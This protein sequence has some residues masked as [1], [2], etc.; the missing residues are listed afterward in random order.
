[1]LKIGLT[2]GF[3]SGKSAVGE[4]FVSLGAKLIKAD[5]I[6][7]QLMLPG[8]PVYEKVVRQFGTEILNAD[9]SIQRAKLAEIA[10]GG[11][12][13]RPS[14][15]HELNEI[16]HPA[17]LQAQEEWMENAGRGDPHAIVMVEAALILEA[18]AEHQFDRLIVV[19]CRPEQRVLR[20]AARL[21]VSLEAA[22]HELERRMAAQIS[23]EEKIKAADYV[24]DNSGT[25]EETRGRVTELF[26]ELKR[27]AEHRRDNARAVQTKK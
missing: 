4:V 5:E 7:H 27:Q 10:F 1:M 6:A 26:G 19:T 13:G 2:G 11:K 16:V 3:A 14:R 22:R 8:K 21:G 9:K 17:V 25:C 15:I 12:D 18:H 24:V 20:L 23:D